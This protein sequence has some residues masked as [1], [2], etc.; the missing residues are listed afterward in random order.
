LSEQG[1]TPSLEFILRQFLNRPGLYIWGAGASAGLA[2]L[3]ASFWTASPIDYLRN[4]RSFPASIPQRSE[5]TQRIVDASRHLSVAD[6]HPGWE[7]RPG[8]EVPPYQE[9]LQRMADPYPRLNLKLLLAK[10]RF[11]KRRPDSYRVLNRFYPSLIANY[12][13]DGLATP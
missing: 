1:K 13:H 7:L 8:T 5:L 9:I 12:N 10:A 4:V 3:G 2:P 11:E 6:I